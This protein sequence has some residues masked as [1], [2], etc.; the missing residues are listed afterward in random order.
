MKRYKI[1]LIAVTLIGAVNLWAANAIRPL[2]N[3]SLEPV[4]FSTYSIIDKVP[5]TAKENMM[6]VL[7]IKGVKHASVSNA[8]SI[9]VCYNA[10]AITETD[11]GQAI[12]KLIHTKLKTTSQAELVSKC[13]IQKSW[14]NNYRNCFNFLQPVFQVFN[15]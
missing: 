6:Q 2:S 12:E 8:N 14:I 5:A 7:A 11:L 3:P 15:S 10:N 9:S 1:L 13:P 4:Q